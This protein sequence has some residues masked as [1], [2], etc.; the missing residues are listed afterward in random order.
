MSSEGARHMNS[1]F[2]KSI[3]VFFLFLAVS[4]CAK[5]TYV[6]TAF[7]PAAGKDGDKEDGDVTCSARFQKSGY[8]VSID[9]QTKPTDTAVGTFIFKVY[10]PNLGDDSPVPID[11]VGSMSVRLTMPSMPSMGSGAPI[12]VEHLDVG[13][14]QANGVFFSM[15]GDWQIIFET[16]QKSGTV[17]DKAILPFKY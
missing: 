4:A 12:T 14:Y 6:S 3:S 13:T 11:L 2:I 15:Q 1:I 10:R 5:P 8:C 17:V 16:K 9:W 7:L